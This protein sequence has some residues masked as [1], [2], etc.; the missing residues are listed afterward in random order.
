MSTFN[1]NALTV[2][3]MVAI[4][5]LVAGGTLEFTRIAVG[6]GELKAGQV[7]GT[8]TKL[9]NQLFDVAIHDVYSDS[10][11]QATIRG[12]FSNSQ[13]ATGFYYRELGLFAKDP[14]TGSE[15]LYAYG[16]AGE[17]AEWIA[18]AGESS[19]IEKEIHIVVLIGNATNVTATL[20]SGIYAIQDDMEAALALKADLD[21]TAEEGGRVLASQMRFDETQTIF[22]DGAATGTNA[23]GSEAN[24]FKTIQAAVNAYYPGARVVTIKIKAGTYAEAVSITNATGT[25]F[26]FGRNGSGTVTVTSLNAQFTNVHVSDITFTGGVSGNAITIANVDNGTLDRVAVQGNSSISGIALYNARAFLTNITVNSCDTAI[27]ARDGSFAAIR[28][29]AGTGNGVGL[30]AFESVITCTEHTMTA[31]TP[32]VRQNGGAINAEGGAASFPSNY[33]QRLNLGDFSDAS[34]LKTA[35]LNEFGKLGIGESRECWFACNI[36]AGFGPFENGQ[37]MT[38]NILKNTTSGSGYGLIIF[39]SHHNVA[40]AY[41]Q[42]QD[43]AFAQAAPVKFADANDVGMK[44]NWTIIQ[45]QETDLE[46]LITGI[47]SV[48]IAASGTTTL[49]ERTNGTLIVDRNIGVPYQLYITDTTNKF[50]KRNYTYD[51]WEAWKELAPPVATTKNYGLVRIADDTDALEDENDEAAI[52]PAVYHDVSD[53]R[54]K[55]TAY[56]VGDKVECMFNFELFLECTQAGTTSNNALDTR[57]VT[58]GQV[59]TDGTAKWTVR[60]HIKSVN[61]TVADASGNVSINTVTNAT[62]ATQDSAGQTIN[63]T[64][65]KGVT[66][67][68]ATLTITKGNGTTSSVTVNNVAHATSADSATKATQ[69]SQGNTINTHYLS[70]NQNTN[71]DMNACTVEGIYRFNGDLK[72]A[73]TGTS[74]GT[75]LVLN[76]QYNGGSGVGGTYLVQLAFPTDGK[77]WTR[78]RVN[79]GAWSS[80]LKVAHITDN[81]ASATKA[82]QDS[83]GNA[84]NTTYLKRSGGTMNG[85]IIMES[86]TTRRIKSGGTGVGIYFTSGE[87]HIYDWKNNVDVLGYNA[88]NQT[89]TANKTIN[90]TVT[91]ATKATQDGNGSTI[92]STYLNRSRGNI[93]SSDFNNAYT[94]GLYNF[95]NYETNRP[96]DYGRLLTLN[97]SYNSTNSWIWQLAFPTRNG[98]LKLRTNT[99]GEGWLSWRTI[100]FTDSP[101]FSGSPTAPT[102]GTTDNS[103]RLATTA[104]AHNLLGR[105]VG[106]TQPTLTALINWDSMKSANGGT[107]VR[108]IKNTTYGVTAYGGDSGSLNKGD[109][110]FKSAFTNYDAILIEHTNDSGERHD[111]TLIPV[112]LLNKKFSTKGCFDLL[113]TNDQQWITR[114]SSCPTRPSTTTRFNVWEQNCGIIEIYGVTY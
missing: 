29:T 99:N 6:D 56:K 19:I 79:T 14:A 54:H 75:L 78:Q 72:N 110:I 109:I 35:I 88:T 16:N 76:N 84:I 33:S 94:E 66:G 25:L 2:Q 55:N 111:F 98:N 22:V 95:G 17:D 26:I 100:P 81:V 5:A 67:S 69:D 64:Y 39:Y 71:N 45:N 101:A 108:N 96:T 92:S 85:D 48:Q 20:N 4:A 27:E 36:S 113:D 57:N 46:N 73:W 107:D 8:M 50:Y 91:N 31:I 74:W 21:N 62:K 51:R 28:G 34:T 12:V 7:P 83:D 13:V 52:T 38:C 11:S 97:N 47:Y 82:T 106:K 30:A 23:D 87:F 61:N 112:W 77:I 18:S 105:A 24:P 114:G 70:R 93:P 63:T 68:N 59:I 15:I 86:S 65:V 42:I 43:G 40:A 3:G 103:T 58:H 10:V 37:R 104:F 41:M 80:W 44:A 102:P 49:P 60:T 53:F 32:Y 90:G 89:L 1:N 9:N